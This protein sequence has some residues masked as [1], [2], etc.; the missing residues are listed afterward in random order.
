VGVQ[1]EDPGLSGGTLQSA[2]S[3][4]GAA[5][6]LRRDEF[7]GLVHGRNHSLAEQ[8]QSTGPKLKRRSRDQLAGL[9]SHSF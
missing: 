5:G 8:T 1:I 7:A 6:I 2:D 4:A 3:L 9:G